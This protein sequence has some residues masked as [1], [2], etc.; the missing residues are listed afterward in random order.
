VV[1]AIGLV[2]APGLAAARAAA[3]WSPSRTWLRVEAGRARSSGRG[4]RAVRGL[5]ASVGVALVCTG[6][7]IGAA[8]LLRHAELGS[9]A[10][11]AEPVDRGASA[12]GRAAAVSSAPTVRGP[13]RAVLLHERGYTVRALLPGLLVAG[14]PFDLVF[15]LWDQ[16]GQPLEVP[17]VPVTLGS[18]A[19]PRSSLAEAD[20]PEPALAARPTPGTPGRY[21]VAVRFAGPGP[22]A[23]LLEL[24]GESSLHLHF[25]VGPAPR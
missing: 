17:A 10:R 12:G 24:P 7:G 4:R 14:R 16:A 23:A 5:V 20:E 2:A 13:L 9:P 15:D 6:A 1:E 8:S 22:A 21:R 11:A 25:D 3:S 19:S 18:L